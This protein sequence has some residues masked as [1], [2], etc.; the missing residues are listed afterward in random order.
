MKKINAW[1]LFVC[2]PEEYFARPGEHSTGNL[3]CRVTFFFFYQISR[4]EVARI[5]SALIQ[6]YDNS[7]FIIPI[8]L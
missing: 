8:F 1:I 2:V 5:I 6:F 4:K 7:W 3:S